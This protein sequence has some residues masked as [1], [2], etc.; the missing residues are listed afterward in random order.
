MKYFKPAVSIFVSLLCLIAAL[1]LSYAECVNI[2][3][4]FSLTGENAPAQMQTIQGIRI[5]S[6][7]IMAQTGTGHCINLLWFDDLNTGNITFDQ[8]GDPV[9]PAVIMEIINGTPHMV[10]NITP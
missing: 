7:E 8:T 4:V 10:Q 6:S 1:P 2:G 9:K 5:A 3:A